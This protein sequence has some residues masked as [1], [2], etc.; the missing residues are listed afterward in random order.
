MNLNTYYI[1]YIYIYISEIFKNKIDFYNY[2]AN[3][4]ELLLFD[5]RPY[6]RESFHGSEPLCASHGNLSHNIVL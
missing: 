4:P 6:R 2:K 5:L 1:I 3:F